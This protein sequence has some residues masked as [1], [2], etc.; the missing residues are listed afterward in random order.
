VAMPTFF[1]LWLSYKIL[2]RTKV[3]PINEVDLLTGLQAIDEG[4]KQFNEEQAAKGP[5]TR[6]RKMW[7][8][9]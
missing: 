3:I 7:D 2:Y 6:W 4:E 9:L 8:S 5:Q 1:G